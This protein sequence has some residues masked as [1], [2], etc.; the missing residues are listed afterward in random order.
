MS[1]T[2]ELDYLDWCKKVKK[3][4]NIKETYNVAWLREYSKK[5]K[6]K[7]NGIQYAIMLGRYDLLHTLSQPLSRQKSETAVI[8]KD[9]LEIPNATGGGEKEDA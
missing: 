4:Q 3:A 7:I 2:P 6:A 5:T 9:S 1:R 8:S